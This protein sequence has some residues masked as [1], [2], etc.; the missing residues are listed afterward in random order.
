ML[1][2]F[3]AV[4]AV[5]PSLLLVWYFHSRDAHPEPGGVLW[6]TFGLGIAAIVPTCIV[7]LPIDALM[8]EPLEEPFA[9]GL[10]GAFLTAAI[11]EELFK[12]LA[13]YLYA[14]R[15]KAFDEPMDGIVYGVMSALGFATFENVLYVADGG[16]GVAVMRAVTAVPGHA[17]CGAIMGAYVG[18]AVFRPAEARPL[19]IKALIWPI[20]LHGLYDFPLLTLK[21][22]GDMSGLSGGVVFLLI[23]ITA[24]T[25]LVEWRWTLQ[26]V[27]AARLQ[28]SPRLLMAEQEAP[29][30]PVVSWLLVGVGFLSASGGGLVLLGCGVA[31]LAGIEPED[32]WAVAVGAGVV[33]A[34]PVVV[35]VVLFAWGVKRR[36]QNTPRRAA[37]TPSLGP[38]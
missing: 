4:S 15:H 14:A 5:V 20:V 29:K 17:F 16:L 3:T 27:R 11:P 33:G 9:K 24:A 32:V 21:A 31:L 26:L 34:L 18:Q 30:S 1:I 2:P 23:G 28:Q 13:L 38:L 12:F 36:V 37:V 10:G 8:L 7:A 22:A 35:G 6:A 25:L 19:L